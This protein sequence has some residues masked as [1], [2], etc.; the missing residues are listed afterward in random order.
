MYV[1]ADDQQLIACCTCP[2]TPNHLQTLSANKDLVS[3]TLTPG[4]PADIS[5]MLVASFGS[6]DASNPGPLVG[7]LRAWSTTLHA[8]PGGTFATTEIPFLD[9]PISGSGFDKMTQL[10]GF[11]KANGS[12]YG[13]CNSCTLGAAGASKQ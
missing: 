8:A 1:F 13:I 9:V 11:I 2:L 6:C 5:I 7:G 12:G 3:N 10:C 4:S